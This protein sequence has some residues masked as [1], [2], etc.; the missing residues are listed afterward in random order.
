[1]KTTEPKINSKSEYFICTPSAQAKRLYLYANSVGHFFYEA[2]YFLHREKY[3]SYLLLSVVKGSLIVKTD[4]MIRVNAGHLVLIDCYAPHTY[5]TDEECECYWIHFDGTMAS[6]YFEEICNCIGN[7][8]VPISDNDDSLSALMNLYSRVI[9]NFSSLEYIISAQITA[10]LQGFLCSGTS[11]DK[12]SKLNN[13]SIQ[14]IR[15]FIDANF[16]Q[17]LSLDELASLAGFSQFHFLRLFK[18]QTG[19]TPHDYIQTVRL[20]HASYLL[21]NTNQPITE[22]CYLCGY[23]S[24]SVFTTA[25]KN[26]YGV[27][28]RE[29]RRL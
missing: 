5:Y 6:I 18:E 29:Y 21:K 9:G 16:D 15:A 2:G 23:S 13:T 24:P 14:N 25:F 26:A 19:Y 3:D 22:I 8:F 10:I 4:S 12:F 17:E 27:T 1:M 20:N 11:S 28:P 7:S